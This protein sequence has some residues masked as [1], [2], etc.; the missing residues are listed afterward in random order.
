MG[1]P[2]DISTTCRRERP[3][4]AKLLAL[5]GACVPLSRDLH[6]PCSSGPCCDRRQAAAVAGS[7][8]C[9][10]G[11]GELS[12]GLSGGGPAWG[13]VRM[14]GLCTACNAGAHGLAHRQ[15][16]VGSC[17]GRMAPAPFLHRR[18]GAK[19][20]AHVAVPSQYRCIV[21]GICMAFQ[22]YEGKCA[23]VP[24][25]SHGRECLV[26]GRPGHGEAG[27]QQSAAIPVRCRNSRCSCYRHV[28]IASPSG[29]TG[30]RT[31]RAVAA[32]GEQ[33]R[34][35]T[36]ASLWKTERPTG[37]RASASGSIQQNDVYP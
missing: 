3:E 12:F 19:S 31:P 10:A 4:V 27:R 34:E 20:H 17:L 37:C 32:H 14:A 24:G 8:A 33:R 23:A 36:G 25:A 28:A 15:S 26:F 22:S 29:N 30:V 2:L 13:G 7:R 18:H 16:G 11:S 9:S 35:P 5:D 6:G 21:G 1:P